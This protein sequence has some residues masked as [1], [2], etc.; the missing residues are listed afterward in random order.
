MKPYRHFKLTEGEIAQNRGGGSYL[1]Q[2][3]FDRDTVRMKNMKSGWV[4][5]AHII[6]LY[7]D[8]TIEWD[9]STNGHFE[10]V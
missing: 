10:E 7:Q 9:Y 2:Q 3:V 6:T 5:I 1:V 4:L 8:G